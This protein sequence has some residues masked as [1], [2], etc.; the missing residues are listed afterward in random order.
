[1]NGR[2]FVVIADGS[3]D[4]ASLS[5]NL[6]SALDIQ[7]V[8][9]VIRTVEWTR[10]E[11]AREDYVCR[12]TQLVGAAKMAYEVRQLRS[13]F[14]NSPI[15]LMGYDAGTR[16]VLAAAEQLPP[17]YV[18]R[19]ILMSPSV[20]SFYDVRPAIRAARCG[21]DVFF[22][23][24]DNVLEQKEAELGPCDGARTRA[25]GLTSFLI[26]NKYKSSLAGDPILSNLRQYDISD[27]LGGHYAALRTPLLQ[28]RVIPL[29]VSGCG[30]CQTL[31][32]PAPPVPPP[33]P[34]GCPTPGPQGPPPP[35]PPGYQPPGPQG[36][37]PPPPP[38][39]PAPYSNRPPVPPAPVPPP[40]PGPSPSYGPPNPPPPPPPAK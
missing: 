30:S 24:S 20:S 11:S 5:E 37:P 10:T 3:N 17:A 27:S 26:A 22:N 6:A 25:A 4:S 15:V 1:L 19:I 40:P 14:P 13:A 7:G 9:V 23:P 21:V 35:V 32:P 12:N 8:R 16:V 39:P 18:D 38:G 33:A 28:Q 2:V 34:P 29:L 31:P 36:P